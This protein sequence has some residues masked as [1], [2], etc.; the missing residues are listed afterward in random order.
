MILFD[1]MQYTHLCITLI[2]IFVYICPIYTYKRIYRHL[3]EKG[4]FSLIFLLNNH[5]DLDQPNQPEQQDPLQF[6][7]TYI[8]NIHIHNFYCILIDKCTENLEKWIS[9][10]LSW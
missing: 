7:S 2:H 5:N 3:S 10:L 4:Y 9:A 6:A 8:N 1:T